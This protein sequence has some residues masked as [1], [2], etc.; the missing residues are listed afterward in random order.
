MKKKLLYG[1]LLFSL[2]VVVFAEGGI[3]LG[4][5]IFVELFCSIHMTV[6]VLWPL[7]KIITKDESKE[8]VRSMTIKLFIIRAIILVIIDVINP[9][10]FFLDFFAIFIGA[11]ILIPIMGSKAGKTFVKVGN[12]EAINSITGIPTVPNYK[13]EMAKRVGLVFTNA[14]E[15]DQ[16]Y[17]MSESNML[18]TFIKRELE[19]NGYN[20]KYIPFEMIKRRKV[21]NLI[22]VFLLFIFIVMIFFHFPILTYIVGIIVLFIY[23]KLSRKFN[24]VKYINKEITSRP[25]DSMKNIIASVM[26]NCTEENNK[27]LLFIG[28]LIAIIVPLI[29]FI[30]PVILYE[31][32]DGGYYVRYYAWGLKEY[33]TASIPSEHNGKPVV[34]LRGNTFSNMYFLESVDLPN[35]IKVM[36][37][38]TFKNCFKLKNVVLPSSLEYLGG[39]AFSHCESLEGI[40]IPDSVTEIGWE[41]FEYCYSLKEVVLPKNLTEIKG[42]TFEGCESLETIEIPSS[43]TRIGG[44]AFY[45]CESLSNVI[46]KEDS[47]LNEIGSS[48]F[49]R[50]DSLR[51]IY[52]PNNVYINE[53]AFKESPTT[54]L[55]FGDVIDEYNKYSLVSMFNLR[56]N[57]SESIEYNNHRKTVNIK[58]NNI[59]DLGNNGYRFDFIITGAFNKE[60][61]LNNIDFTET[62]IN[63]DMKIKLEYY[64]GDYIGVKVYHY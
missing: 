21:L 17:Q 64:T 13:D 54:I 53:R 56:L 20:D 58:L 30:N 1:L 38:Q 44:H 34:G 43:V 47:K 42:N 15:Y 62:E 27:S 28:S 12:I 60:F 5:A 4:A 36:R 25:S 8:K 61:S 33:K 48:A 55:H 40:V 18:D 16:M 9:N 19:K 6:F 26:S 45:G 46:I 52:L 3:D 11:F 41:S 32:A 10:L 63:E 2:P 22:F 59:E 57:Q 37:G 35:S 23:L 50:C 49:R 14:N 29:M 39:G 24:I 31:E 51:T 7:A